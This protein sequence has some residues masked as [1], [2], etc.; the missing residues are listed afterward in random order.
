MLRVCE[1]PEEASGPGILGVDQRRK[2][3]SGPYIF[4]YKFE[5]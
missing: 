5:L 1:N 2:Q 3:V 4:E